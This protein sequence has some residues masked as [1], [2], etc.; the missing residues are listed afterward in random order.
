MDASPRADMDATPSEPRDL[1]CS[2]YACLEVA[3]LV[4]Q[5]PD[6]RSAA[7]PRQPLHRA[8]D[9]VV[10]KEPEIQHP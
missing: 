7:S 1:G 8:N 5:G 2:R 6:E 10:R 3:S 9:F 4:E